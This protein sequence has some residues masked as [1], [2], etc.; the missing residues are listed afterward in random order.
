MLASMSTG[1]NLSAT[2][3]EAQAFCAEHRERVAIGTCDRCGNFFCVECAGRSEATQRYCRQCDATRS[4]VAWEDLSLPLGQRYL[5]T[6]KSSLFELPRFAAELP[7]RGPLMAPLVY[8]LLPTLI[9][10]ALIAGVNV[11][12]LGDLIESVTSPITRGKSGFVDA[13]LFGGV[14]VAAM[15]SFIA[16]LVLAPLVLLLSAHA[17][18]ARGVS[19]RGLFRSLCYASGFNFLQFFPVFAPFV[20]VYHVVL[21]V[22]C[23]AASAKVRVLTAIGIYATPAVLIGGCCGGSYLLLMLS[24]FLRR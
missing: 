3:Q 12:L 14:L 19:Y 13:T 1:D 18:G 6:L 7:T 24:V 9:S 15:A 17:F 16:Y 2:S 21:C 10:T 20:L 11:L 23:I 4:Y 8:A 5:Q 22:A